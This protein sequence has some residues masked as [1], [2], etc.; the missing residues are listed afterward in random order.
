MTLTDK[1]KEFITRVADL[2]DE[3]ERI[4]TF[5]SGDYDIIVELKNNNITLTPEVV[6]EYYKVYLWGKKN[7][8]ATIERTVALI[9]KNVLGLE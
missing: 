4:R 2:L 1:F 6:N 8:E 3:D 7:F 9:K 5:V